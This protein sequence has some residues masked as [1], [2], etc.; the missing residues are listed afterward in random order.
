MVDLEESSRTIWEN[1]H[2]KSRGAFTSLGTVLGLQGNNASTDVGIRMV[3]WVLH[4]VFWVGTSESVDRSQTSYSTSEFRAILF[5]IIL[6]RGNGA[7][8][9]S[10]LANKGAVENY[11]E[12]IVGDRNSSFLRSVAQRFPASCQFMHTKLSGELSRVQFTYVTNP[13]DYHTNVLDMHEPRAALS[14]DG[15]ALQSPEHSSLADSGDDNG[16][17]GAAMSPD[18]V[19]QSYPEFQPLGC[20]GDCGDLHGD[21]REHA[22]ALQ[23]QMQRRMNEHETHRCEL[24]LENQRLKGENK[25]LKERLKMCAKNHQCR[26]WLNHGKC[27]LS[28]MSCTYLHDT[29]ARDAIPAPYKPGGYRKRA[30]NP[31]PIPS[32]TAATTPSSPQAAPPV[33]LESPWQVVR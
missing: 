1:L 29:A 31:S 18:H 32:A 14:G 20:R 17:I 9:A 10:V 19:L 23:E 25:H 24:K 22:K 33:A 12:G 27:W 7:A 30:R 8:K 28:N 5:D 2:L 21:F 13:Q 6:E 3:E 4:N 26:L 16:S 15:P 11:L